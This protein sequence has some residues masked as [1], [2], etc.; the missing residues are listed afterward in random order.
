MRDLPEL[1]R[2]ELEGTG[3]DFKAI[4]YT[5][6]MHEDLLKDVLAMANADVEG[7]RFIIMGVKLKPDGTREFLGVPPDEFRDAAEYQQL[8]A[9]N[10]EPDL[11]VDYL[12]VEVE[13]E[14]IG[15]M[16]I[17]ACNDPPY[18]M[19][20]QYGDLQR[21]DGFIRKGT[22][23]LRLTRSDHDRFTAAKLDKEDLSGQFSVSFD[24]G[25]EVTEVA[26]ATVGN[27]SLPSDVAA[28]RI[29]KI[30]DERKK[31]AATEGDLGWRV[32]QSLDF[33]SSLFGASKPYEQRSTETLE[34]N[35]ENVKETYAEH[36]LHHVFEERA[37]R[38]Q[39]FVYNS[40]NSYIEDASIRIYVPSF[41]G[42]LIP[43]HVYREPRPARGPLSTPPTYIDTDVVI[44]Y[45]TVNEMEDGVQVREHIGDIRHRMWT[46][47]F[48]KKLRV[49]IKP[50][51]EGETF[52]IRYQVFA[53]NLPE[54][55]EGELVV[56]VV[57]RSDNDSSGG[58]T[59]AV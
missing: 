15:V 55:A 14:L 59:H 37:N 38:V 4:Q 34:K 48:A 27:L 57:E 6:P 18:L 11:Q 23:Q 43:D 20:K 49:V 7:S 1:I 21:G 24:S 9:Q 31:E 56:H 54:P 26:L 30:L 2:F 39:L 16:R 22:H 12:P 35:L 42:L 58:R 32:T 19:R 28:E 25:E 41:D 3:V 17:Y 13:D 5:K 10:I 45:P 46:P 53:K 40:G 33:G 51:L 50:G 44:P 52:T 29:R 36:D 8:I 47:V